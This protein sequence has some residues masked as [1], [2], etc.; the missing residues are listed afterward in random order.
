[1]TCSV[2][3]SRMRQVKHDSAAWLV[4][5]GWTGGCYGVGRRIKLKYTRAIID[6]IHSGELKA[7]QY[8]NTPVFNLQVSST[9]GRRV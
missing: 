7:K 2:N 9:G 1:V 6:A 8:V 3:F 4:N 5:T